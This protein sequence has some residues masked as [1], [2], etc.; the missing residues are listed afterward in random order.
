[1]YDT[2]VAAAERALRRTSTI[3]APWT[4]VEG[5]DEAYRSLTVATSIR[6]AIRKALVQRRGERQ[7]A[8]VAGGSGRQARPVTTGQSVSQ[9]VTA[10]R[11]GGSAAAPLTILS[12]LDMSQAVSKKAF[13]TDLE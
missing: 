6:D 7:T 4:I 11:M 9:P 13:A 1:M 2:F 12:S 5:V 10:A 8:N 3:E